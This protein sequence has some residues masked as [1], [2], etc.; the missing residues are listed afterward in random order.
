MSTVVLPI[1]YA[2]PIHWYAIYAQKEEVILEAKE[3]FVKQSFR[4]RCEIYS[5]NGKQAL[6]APITH[7]GKRQ[8]MAQKQLS[9]QE[10]WQK[11][12]W[13]SL[14]AAYRSSPYFEFYEDDFKP[15]FEQQPKGLM[16]W[17]LQLHQLICDSI[18]LEEKHQLSDVYHQDYAED[19]RSLGPKNKNIKPN[20]KYH[21]VFEEK[22]GFIPAL[23]IFDLLFNLGPESLSYLEEMNI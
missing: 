14:E 5:P 13:K 20:P 17:N 8:T 15:L 19:F 18:G 4:N 16:D 22:H 21:Q 10:N 1:C 11:N 3:H 23:S 9:Y 7:K 12:H 6:V 2:A